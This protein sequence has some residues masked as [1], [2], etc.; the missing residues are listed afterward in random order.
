VTLA[1]AVFITKKF[2]FVGLH[3]KAPVGLEMLKSGNFACGPLVI[4]VNQL[5][6]LNY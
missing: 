2:N 6:R 1:I 4:I 5:L 3:V